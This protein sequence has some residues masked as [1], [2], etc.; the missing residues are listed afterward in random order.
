MPVGYVLAP[1][2]A[3]AVTLLPRPT[4]P[5]KNPLTIS[6]IREGDIVGVQSMLRKATR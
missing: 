3:R 2:I 4:A 6:T 1:V 5:T